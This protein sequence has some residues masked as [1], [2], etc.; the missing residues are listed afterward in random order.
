MNKNLMKSSNKS[1]YSVLQK[2]RAAVG[3]FP[4]STSNKHKGS[5]S[6]KEYQSN[7]KSQ[8]EQ[9]ASNS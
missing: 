4:Q 2:K 7:V 8:E 3:G 5:F 1:V 9:K 6:Q